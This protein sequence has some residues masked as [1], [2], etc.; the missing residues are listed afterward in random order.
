M[1][2]KRITIKRFE[3]SALILC[4]AHF[5]SI[6]VFHTSPADRQNPNSQ[7]PRPAGHPPPPVAACHFVGTATGPLTAESCIAQF[8][9]KA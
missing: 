7:N 8:S 3:L 4:C 2:L 6:L 9:G 5:G 1:L